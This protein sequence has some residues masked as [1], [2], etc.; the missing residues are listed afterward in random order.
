MLCYT[1]HVNA[2]AAPVSI[3]DRVD[4]VRQRIA[5]AASGT[6]RDAGTVTLIAVSKMVALD[7]VA[8]ALAA[9][10]RDF[11]ENRVQDLVQ[12]V[13][14]LQDR[15]VCRWHLIGHLQRNKARKAVRVSGAIHSIDSVDLALIV[16]REA[17]V[18]GRSV[19]VFAEV[20]TSGERSKFGFSPAGLRD[21]AG[22]L[23]GIPFLRWRGLMTVAP[24]EAT[25]REL[26]AIFASARLLREELTSTFDRAAWDSL[27]MGMTNDFEIAIEE[28]ATHI[29]V[30]RAIFGER[31]ALATGGNP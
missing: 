5:R 6:G 3:Q 30:G 15:A 31:A 11:G 29:R 19:D 20:N 21:C 22:T 16:G 17:A 28:G 12:R 25:T 8:G 9:G 1:E 13:A 4:T 2:V 7:A 14:A 23:A 18:L 10:V 27:S 26:H 24:E